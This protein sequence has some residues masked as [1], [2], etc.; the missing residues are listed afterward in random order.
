MAHTIKIERGVPFPATAPRAQLYPFH[1]ME[2]GDSFFVP[3]ST[4]N[5]LGS[6]AHAYVRSRKPGAK[7]TC[8][9]IDGGVRVWRI[10]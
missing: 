4:T 7:F 10:S 8:R 2:V 6:A 5:R 9:T 1:E 3:D